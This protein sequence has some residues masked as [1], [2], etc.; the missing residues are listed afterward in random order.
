MNRIHDSIAASSFDLPSNPAHSASMGSGHVLESV[1]EGDVEA[2]DC[3]LPTEDDI[4][5]SFRV[6]QDGSMTVEMKVRLTLKEEESIHWT[7]TLSR[8]SVASQTNGNSLPASEVEQIESVIS[9]SLDLQSP[10]AATDGIKNDISEEDEEQLLLECNGALSDS[11]SEDAQVSPRRTPTPGRNHI[12]QKQ[13]S[14]ESITSVS[15]EG[16]NEGTITSFS[17]KEQTEHTAMAQQ[18]C[19]FKQKSTKPVPKPRRFGSVDGNSRNVRTLESAGMTEF[20]QLESSGDEVTETVFHIYEQQTCQDN[21][22][23]NVSGNPFCRAPSSGNEP[24]PEIW[25]PWTASESISM[26]RAENMSRTSAQVLPT[27]KTKEIQATDF[28][29]PTDT[30][31]HREISKDRT[32]VSKPKVT[33]KHGRIM[34]PGK[35]QKEKSAGKTKKQMQVKPLLGTGLLKKNFGNKPRSAKKAKLRRQ[36]TPQMDDKSSGQRENRRE[37]V[38]LKENKDDV[39]NKSSL[40]RQPSVHEGTKNQS[41]EET[42]SLPTFDSSGS[43]ADKYVEKWLEQSQLH[44]YGE[45]KRVHVAKVPMTSERQAGEAPKTDLFPDNVRRASVKQRILSFETKSSSQSVEKRSSQHQIIDTDAKRCNITAQ[46]NLGEIQPAS[47]HRCYENIPHIEKMLTESEKRSH[48]SKMSLRNATPS[49]PLSMELPSPPPPAEIAELLYGDEAVIPSE[50]SGMS[51]RVSSGRSQTSDQPSSVDQ[52]SETT[53]SVQPDGSCTPLSTAPSTKRVALVSNSS[54]DRKM[55]LRKSHLDKY[56][57]SCNETLSASNPTVAETKPLDLGQSAT[58]LTGETVVHENGPSRCSPACPARSESEGRTSTGSLSSSE[59]SAPS[60]QTLQSSAKHTTPTHMTHMG[61]DEKHATPNAGSSAERQQERPQ[62]KPPHSESLE[63]VSPPG[64]HRSGK[65]LPG[66]NDSLENANVTQRRRLFKGKSEQPAETVRSTANPSVSNKTEKQVRPQRHHVPN[67]AK[68]RA[69]VEELCISLKSIR[70]MLQSRRASCLERSNSRPDF[71]SHVESLFGSSSKALLAFLSV[72]SLKDGI[73]NH[74]SN[75]LRANAVSCAE[76]LKMIDSLR[77]IAAVEDSHQLNGRLL[78]LQQSASKQL[79]ES[80]KSFRQFSNKSKSYSSTPD[81]EQ[82]FGCE[83]PERGSDDIIHEIMDD[84]DI[85]EELKVELASLSEEATSDSD[86]S[87][88]IRDVSGGNKGIIVRNEE[89]RR[90][91]SSEVESQELHKEESE[92]VPVDEGSGSAEEHRGGGAAPGEAAQV[93]PDGTGYVNGAGDDSSD[94]DC[95]SEGD[96][97][98]A[99]NYDVELN[100]RTS[101]VESESTHVSKGGFSEMT[102]L[103]NSEEERL[104][105]TGHADVDACVDGSAEEEPDSEEEMAGHQSAESKA[106][107]RNAFEE[108]ESAEE[109]QE[110]DINQHLQTRKDKSRERMNHHDSADEE[111]GND[112]SICE[113]PAETEGPKVSCPAEDEFSYYEKDLSSEVTAN[114]YGSREYPQMLLDAQSDGK[115]CENVAKQIENPSKEVVS[116]TIAERVSLLEK[117]VSDAQRTRQTVTRSSQR[118]PLL[119]SDGEDPESPTSESALASR[120]APQ[121]SLSFSYDSSGVITTEPERTRVKS[122]REMFLAKSTTD[123]RRGNGTTA[124]RR[125][126][127]SVSGDHQPQT[128]SDASSAEDDSAQKSISRGFV[129]K[130]IERL[131]GKK[132]VNPEE[133]AGERPP[134]APEQ[135]KKDHSRIFSPFHN[136]WSKAGSELSYFNSTNAL[137]TLSEGTKCVA[138]KAQVK[139]GEALPSENRQFL[140]RKSVSEPVG[141]NQGITTPPQAAETLEDPEEM[142]PYSLFELEDKNPPQKKC[143]YFSLP[144]AGE[145][146][147]CQDELSTASRVIANGDTVADSKDSK[148]WAE[149]NGVLP[150]V[151]ITDFKK[152]DNKVHPLVE[153]PP[154]G[155]VVV[156]QPVR[157]RGVA[158]RRLPEPDVLDLLYNFCGQNC[159]IL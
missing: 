100:A 69:V 84:L 141:I 2:Q 82:A 128:R 103:S 153:L 70:Q 4:E 64:R 86:E 133:E 87:E 85:P 68:M 139:P 26:W 92:T 45:S 88:M 71:S 98:S 12:R 29:D 119:Q 32:I 3:V 43:A 47:N 157:G 72:M 52:T 154:D 18:F 151:G 117:L 95:P 7:T 22:L 5:K 10:A 90:R 101:S 89:R 152:M 81:S 40:A 37:T 126:E 122:I 8:S 75:D 24:Q 46:S 66:G 57:V 20:L 127:T 131:Y 97:P 67:Q 19:M 148:T 44:T 150:A 62:P 109:A 35:R 140:I 9:Q 65:K 31:Q 110:E 145:S 21:F 30:A 149:R 134:S 156:A 39:P 137:E 33:N 41:E 49:H 108:Q 77:E 59:P 111:S 11:I 114:G 56:T 159:P 144:H 96:E 115:T 120:S 78:T 60:A 107:V 50:T 38:P 135:K 106:I 121:S 113:A 138:F 42:T 158:N 94:L 132:D 99:H 73:T 116:Q 79:M 15:A 17:Y 14:V 93:E 83:D 123:N 34:S 147:M 124:S 130:T 16:I 112:H 142:T 136:T 1:A 118:G 63:M 6:N 105:Q 129:R 104:T 25:R 55:S 146:D 76:A 27:V 36:Q 13:A 74:H 51:S 53:T 143:T 28:T 80:W 102:G 91:R 155:E 61:G 58:H 23:A 125:A 48:P 54:F